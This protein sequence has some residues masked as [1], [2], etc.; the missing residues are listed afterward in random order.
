M[1]IP[2]TVTLIRLTSVLT[3]FEHTTTRLVVPRSITTDD[4]LIVRHR[5]TEKYATTESFTILTP[6]YDVITM[7]MGLPKQMSHV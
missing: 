1:L 7:K 6:G 3:G 2:T 5:K 4:Y